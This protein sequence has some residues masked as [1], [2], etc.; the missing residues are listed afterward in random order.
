M[1]F[2]VSSPEKPENAPLY[3]IHTDLDSFILYNDQSL[4]EPRSENRDTNQETEPMDF[5]IMATLEEYDEEDHGQSTKNETQNKQ[6]IPC[7]QPVSHPPQTNAPRE[8]RDNPQP[9]TYST[10]QH[11]GEPLWEMNFNGSCTKKTAGAGVWI[12][13]TESDY[14]EIHAINLHFKCTKNIAEYEALIQGLNILKKLGARRITVL[15]NPKL[16]IKQVNGEYAEKH[17]RLREYRNDAMI[18]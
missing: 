12:H 15:R 8:E 6:E 1:K 2:L 11:N 9:I 14:A 16:V 17:P 3:S 13:N 7:S 5:D 18:Y 10:T 4:E